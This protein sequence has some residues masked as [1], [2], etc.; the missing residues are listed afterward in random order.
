MPDR[1]RSQLE[2]LHRVYARA[3]AEELVRWIGPREDRPDGFYTMMRYQ[4]GLSADDMPSLALAVDAVP[5]ALLCLHACT[6]VGGSWRDALGPATSILLLANWFA[7][8]EQIEEHRRLGGDRRALWQRWGDPQAINAGDGMFPVAG[9]AILDIAGDGDTAAVLARELAAVSLSRM[10]GQ[11][12]Q[13][14]MGDRDVGVDVLTRVVSLK[15]GALAGYSAWAGATMGTASEDTRDALRDFG[16]ALG[17][18]RGLW[19]RRAVREVDAGAPYT[20]ASTYD[21]IAHYLE[22]AVISLHRVVLESGGQ[23]RLESFARGLVR[24]R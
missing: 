13:L 24:L 11:H 17:T 5:D 19:E 8:H 23:E 20:R 16:S 2:E 9:R 18:A 4:L 10:E 15:D 1:E 14:S 7:V 3:I 12:M 22:N 6:A 21:V